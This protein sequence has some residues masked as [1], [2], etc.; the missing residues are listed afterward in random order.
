MNFNESY[1][2]FILSSLPA[3]IADPALYPLSC[4]RGFTT[5]EA[6]KIVAPFEE[7]RSLHGLSVAAE[8]LMDAVLEDCERRGTS[9]LT[10]ANDPPPADG[11]S[12]AAPREGERVGRTAPYAPASATVDRPTA[13]GG[14]VAGPANPPPAEGRVAG[15][16]APGR[17]ASKGD[18]TPGSL[19]LAAAYELVKEGKPVSMRAACKRA[20]V[21]RGHVRDKYPEVAEAIDQMGTPDTDR[22]PR[23]YARNRRTGDIEA[24]A[25]PED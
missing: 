12:R 7:P 24:V 19:V 3:E 2:F 1:K 23:T 22:V 5:S 8:R 18:L 16:I 13:L 21:D 9:T 14:P 6:D 11:E 4:T 25:D 20:K 15:P 10:G 17:E